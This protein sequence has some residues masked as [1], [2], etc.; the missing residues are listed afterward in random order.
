MLLQ[1]RFT[2]KITLIKNVNSSKN[3]INIMQ[4]DKMIIRKTIIPALTCLALLI[5]EV[6]SPGYAKSVPA[7]KYPPWQ[8]AVI[9]DTQNNSREDS[10]S[11][12]INEE[13]LP[14]IAED[15]ADFQPDFVLV[16]GDLVNGWL[17][18][19]GTDYSTQYKTWNSAMKPVYKKG[20]KIYA[21]RGNHDS[22]P[23]RVALRRLPKHLEPGKKSLLKL[24][25]SFKIANIRK[26]TPQNGPKKEKGL[27]YS[28]IH[29]NAHFI[30][31]DQYTNGQHKVNQAWLARQLYKKT[32]K[33]LFIF[34][35]EP[36]F[37]TDYPDNLSF[38]RKKRDLFWN[39][40]GR[41]GA[42]VYFCGHDHFYNRSLI[43]DSRGNGVWQIIGG[44]GGGKLQKW[45]GNYKESSRVMCEYHNSDHYGYILVTIDGMEATIQWRALTDVQDREWEVLD[46]F[47]YTSGKALKK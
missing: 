22:G 46:S 40:I 33:H 26:Y 9:S 27:T 6:S 30:G 25:K 14:L 37:G 28:F 36:A 10:N 8:F 43:H 45:S 19:G 4:Q 1:R 42:K 7:K 18:N 11:V 38:Y 15:I 3:R 44:T 23:E 35:H 13:I 41:G 2:K 5:A 24:K 29:K 34:G 12:C 47:S 16:S 20:I 39:I 21:V 31:L 32:K 17:R